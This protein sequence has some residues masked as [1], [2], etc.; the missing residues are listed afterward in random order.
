MA[1]KRSRFPTAEAFLPDAPRATLT[2]L[3][4]AAAAC[5][6]CDLYK[7]ATQTVF[8]EGPSSADIILVG[9]QPGDRE[10]KEGHPF[11]GPAGALLDKA[12]A[13]AGI[14]RERVYITNAVKHFKWTPAPRGKRRIHSKPSAAQ[15]RACM[16]W[17]REEVRA[18]SP[19]V[20]VVLG[21]TAG[22]ALLG[23]SF[24]VTKERGKVL[25]G[26]SW[27]PAAVVS[28]IHPSAALRAPDSESRAREYAGLVSDL[29]VAAKAADRK[30]GVR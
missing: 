16:P 14:E 19:R 26:T 4:E 1:A 7:N 24:R 6:G 21:A 3:R 25:E 13:E 9:E 18:V 5:K 10:D 8:G 27:A 28:T 20:I 22:E 23:S 17:F 2:Q 11:V 15:V 29:K 12:L 30:T